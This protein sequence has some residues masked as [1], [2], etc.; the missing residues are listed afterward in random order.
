M[1]SYL[2]DET[3]PLVSDKP[4]KKKTSAIPLIGAGVSTYWHEWQLCRLGRGL[5]PDMTMHWAWGGLLLEGVWWGMLGGGPV[6]WWRN[7]RT[8]E[9]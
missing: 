4:S 9:R 1:A 8:T 3:T 7:F 5:E 2:D 6:G